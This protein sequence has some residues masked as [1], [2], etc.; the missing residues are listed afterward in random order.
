MSWR[1][2][3]WE[4]PDWGFSLFSGSNYERGKERYI[5]HEAGAD[6]ILEALKAKALS[7]R[8]GTGTSID[9]WVVIIPEA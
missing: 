9:G 3:D 4:N 1:P 5:A 2:P 7:Y 8:T 6:A